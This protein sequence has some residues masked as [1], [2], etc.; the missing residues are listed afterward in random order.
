MTLKCCIRDVR[1]DGHFMLIGSLFFEHELCLGLIFLDQ[2][3]I[4]CGNEIQQNVV[5]FKPVRLM[6]QSPWLLDN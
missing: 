3:K 4:S 5:N 2:I 6:T 1:E